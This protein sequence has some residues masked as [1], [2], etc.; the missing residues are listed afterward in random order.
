MVNF[1]PKNY[2]MTKIPVPDEMLGQTVIVFPEKKVDKGFT[3][4]KRE[5]KKNQAKGINEADWSSITPPKSDFFITSRDELP[6]RNWK[7]F[8]KDIDKGNYISGFGNYVD[9]AINN[10]QNAGEVALSTLHNLGQLVGETGY[11][12][13]K[14]YFNDTE[15]SA[16][17]SPWIEKY[18]AEYGGGGAGVGANANTTSV[19]FP[20]IAFRSDF[21]GL[22][23]DISQPKY[24]EE[25]YDPLETVA[26]MLMNVDFINADMSR[27]A[28]ALDKDSSSK[29]KNKAAVH[30][31]N[32]D[33]RVEAE[34]WRA[35]RK[36][37][38]EELKLNLAEKNAALALQRWQAMQPKALGGNK[39]SWI[40]S[41]G[42]IHF[43]QVDKQG[44]SRTLGENSAS[45]DLLSMSPKKLKKMTPKQILE[46]AKAQSLLLKDK[47]AQVPF[48]QGYILQ[49]NQIR[50]I[51]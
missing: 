3:E 15:K 28:A 20:S 21:K 16:D 50:G 10:P 42:N 32:E 47:S 40:D 25:E 29:R 5:S 11:G 33:A 41:A 14:D 6:N 17:V 19:P 13:I 24:V 49:A 43:E 4:I 38:L 39:M 23:T 45:M 2:G 46:R 30:N 9:K 26:K 8:N 44:E 34:K 36:M 27:A 31:A 1:T 7:Q 51:D 12:L 48:V 35:A 18:L 22:D 37:A